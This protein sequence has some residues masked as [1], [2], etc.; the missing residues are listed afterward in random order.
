MEKHETNEEK[1]QEIENEI[2]AYCKEKLVPF[3]CPKVIH[4]TD[5]IPRTA[6]GKIQRREVAQHFLQVAAKVAERS[7]QLKAHPIDLPV[8]T[9][10]SK[11]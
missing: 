1:V 6:T 8:R 4:I 9:V 3:K 10:R 7:K 5:A 2:M 11:L